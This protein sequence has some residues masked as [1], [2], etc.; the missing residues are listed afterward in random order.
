MTSAPQDKLQWAA[1]MRRKH[2]LS[3]SR[4]EPSDSYV[5]GYCDKCVSVHFLLTF[6]S[7]LFSSLTDS[8]R[9]E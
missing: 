6:S 1:G 5:A 4:R 8:S 3:D 7:V 2:S 9:L